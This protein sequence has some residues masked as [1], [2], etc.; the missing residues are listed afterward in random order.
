MSHTSTQASSINQRLL[1]FSELPADVHIAIAEQCEVR[2]LP[3]FCS[4]MKRIHKSCIHVLYRDVDLSVHNR[5]IVTV[6]HDDEDKQM[7]SDNSACTIHNKGLEHK[8]ITFLQTLTSRPEYGVY[9]HKL[10]WSLQLLNYA[11]RNHLDPVLAGT[12]GSALTFRQIFHVL[13]L[14]TNVRAIDIAW[15]SEPHQIYAN[16][17]SSFLPPSLFSSATSVCLVGVMG[18]P[19]ASL[20]PKSIPASNLQHLVLSTLQECGEPQRPF[21]FNSSSELR[22]RVSKPARKNP[23]AMLG[24]LASLAGRC[25]NLKTLTLRKVAKASKHSFDDTFFKHDAAVY[26]EMAAF[27]VSVAPTLEKL[28]FEQGPL[29]FLQSPVDPDVCRDHAV[30]WE[31]VQSGLAR[32]IQDEQDAA[33]AMSEW[34]PRS[35]GTYRPMDSAFARTII[36]AIAGEEWPRL[37]EVVL[38]GIGSFDDAW[39]VFP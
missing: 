31:G 11:A 24:L 27:I 25:T 36:P 5:G 32:Q 6:R 37:K 12:E 13:Q 2:H 8:Q 33:K 19:L 14:L 1:P 15:I 34:P 39:Y 23:G 16:K 35:G 9:V 10:S 18:R 7:W 22:I 26:E 38:K 3:V 21:D 20:I 30:M 17:A 29:A 4:I 28:T